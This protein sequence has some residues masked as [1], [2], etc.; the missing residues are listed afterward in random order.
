[1]G[2]ASG[3]GGHLRK[4]SPIFTF[5]LAIVFLHAFD[6][7]HCSSC[8]PFEFLLLCGSLLVGLPLSHAPSP[9]RNLFSLLAFSSAVRHF[10]FGGRL[11]PP[12]FSAPM[13]A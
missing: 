3:G 6:S 7:T 1:M 8:R 2:H 4:V 12:A 13:S 11:Q 10:Q 9:F 5:F